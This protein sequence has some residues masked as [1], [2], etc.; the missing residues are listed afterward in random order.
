MQLPP[1]LPLQPHIV[2]VGQQG[3]ERNGVHPGHDEA[4]QVQ[5]PLWHARLLVHA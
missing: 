1:K 4:T 2:V 3:L 5:T